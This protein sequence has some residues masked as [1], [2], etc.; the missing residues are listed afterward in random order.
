MGNDTFATG[1]ISYEKVDELCRVLREF[2]DIMR[3]YKVEDF[4]AYG[5]SAIR[6]T[7]NTMIV[8][9]QIRQ[10]TGIRIEVLSLS[11]IHILLPARSKL[12]FSPLL[13]PARQR[14]L[15]GTLSLG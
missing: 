5:T 3:G 4:K 9:D 8:L 15:K 11:L 10:R 13:A 14:S 1:K 2:V 12:S 7:E 6:E